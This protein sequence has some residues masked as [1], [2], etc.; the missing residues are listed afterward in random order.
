MTDK[1]LAEIEALVAQ[2]RKDKLD[3]S[4]VDSSCDLWDDVNDTVLELL[5]EIRRLQQEASDN[6]PGAG[7]S[8]S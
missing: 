5:A 8:V 7:F 4:H 6:G 3:W 1:R 2:S